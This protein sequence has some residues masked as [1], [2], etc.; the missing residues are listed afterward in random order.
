MRKQ[1][2]KDRIN[3]VRYIVKGF[4]MRRIKRKNR[5]FTIVEVLVVIVLLA[6]IATVYVPRM[7]RGLGQ[8]K[9]KIAKTQMANIE[10]AIVR[11]YID[12][13]RYPDETEGLLVLIEPPPDVEDKWKGPYLKESQLLDPWEEPFVYVED[14]TKPDGYYLVSYGKDRLE[15]GEGDDEDIFND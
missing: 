9:R 3:A 14:P 13:E 2:G 6:L 5:A 15:G 12:C 4:Q 8:Q 1:I 7:Y 10:S 11:F